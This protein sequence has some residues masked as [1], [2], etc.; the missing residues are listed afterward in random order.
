MAGQK[1]YA[2][3][4]PLLLEGYQEMV[5]RK[6]LIG[7]PDWYHLDGAGEWVV[8]LYT[9]SGKPGKAAEWKKSEIHQDTATRRRV[10]SPAPY[11]VLSAVT[12]IIGSSVPNEVCYR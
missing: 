7:V 8:Q 10:L 4:E 9:S 5:A 3:A 6:D 12:R 1:K 11:L 2:E